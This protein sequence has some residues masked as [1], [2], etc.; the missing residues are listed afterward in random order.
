MKNSNRFTAVRLF[1]V[2]GLVLLFLGLAGTTCIEER[3]VEMVVGSDLIA[4][5]EATSDTNVFDREE[6]IRIADQINLQQILEDNG[7]DS[8]RV[9]SVQSA[10]FRVT[11]KDPASDRTIAGEIRVR[12]DTEPDSSLISFSSMRVCRAL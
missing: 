1:Q 6:T 2:M 9:V 10:F 8:I 5:F 11:R 4:E 12:R 7:I 3:V